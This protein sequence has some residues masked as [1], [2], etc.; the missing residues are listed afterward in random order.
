MPYEPKQQDWQKIYTENLKQFNQQQA[1]DDRDCCISRT[2]GEEFSLLTELA[3]SASVSQ[4]FL[5][6]ARAR[7]T[8][9]G[10]FRSPKSGPAR[11]MS[12]NSAKKITEE[13]QIEI[14]QPVKANSKKL[15]VFDKKQTQQ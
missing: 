15:N 8:G 2:Q 7:A 12:S 11:R 14:T 10:S 3:K 13:T 5:L 9:V 4:L 6:L 1:N